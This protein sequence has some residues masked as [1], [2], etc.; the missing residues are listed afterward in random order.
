VGQAVWF[1]SKQPAGKS[2]HKLFNYSCLWKVNFDSF[3]ARNGEGSLREE[4]GNSWVSGSV[5]QFLS[6]ATLP[7]RQQGLGI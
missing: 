1:P 2:H 4:M 7:E 3:L 6:L 5:K